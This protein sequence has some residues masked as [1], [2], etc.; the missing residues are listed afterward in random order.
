M[1][2]GGYINTPTIIDDI[3]KTKLTTSDITNGCTV[4]A[5]LLAKAI[6]IGHRRP[7]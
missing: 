6:S 4:K 3:P 7:Y 1:I 2:E 5:A